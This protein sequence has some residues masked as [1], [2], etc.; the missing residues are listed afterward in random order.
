MAGYGSYQYNVL[1][2]NPDTGFDLHYKLQYPTAKAHVALVRGGHKAEA[3]IQ[4]TYYNFE[5]G[6]Q[7]PNNVS[8]E[9]KEVHIPRQRSMESAAYIT[10]QFDLTKKLNM[11][12]GLRYSLFDAL[13]EAD[14]NLYKPN[15]LLAPFNQV[16]TLHVNKGEKIKSFNNPEP[17][18]AFKYAF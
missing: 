8:S 11:T 17:R 3:G 14:V 2:E 1:D 5:P 12:V 10:D 16:G 13:G 18:I 9:I 6:T 15:A 7:I 4:S